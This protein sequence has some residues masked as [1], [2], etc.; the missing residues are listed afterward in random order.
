M[1][2]IK[3]TGGREL[4]LALKQLPK[5]LEQNVMRQA[6]RA[7][8]KVIQDKAKELVPVHTGDL[9]KSLKLSTRSRKGIVTVSV[10]TRG[11][12]AYI[13]RFIEF[14]TAPHL[15][16]GRNGGMLK[17]VA[18]DGNTVETASVNHPGIKAKPFLRPSLDAKAKEAII[19]VGEKIRS[20]LSN[21]GYQT[22]LPLQADEE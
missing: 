8:A 15:I 3:I 21:L 17:F 6:L 14:G 16:K 20:R 11:K 10:A 9:K 1:K 18:R 12:G 22:P 13:A 7:G 19:A 4:A 5:Q 2:N